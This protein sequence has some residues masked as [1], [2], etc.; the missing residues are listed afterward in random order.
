M[1]RPSEFFHGV[2]FGAGAAR[3]VLYYLLIAVIG[4]F[5]NLWWSGVARVVELP[6]P[7]EF[8]SWTAA[9]SV[10]TGLVSFFATPFLAAIGLFLWCGLLHV[11]VLM[12]SRQRRG[13][14]ATVRAVSY[15]AGPTVLAIVP[16]VGGIIGFF[17]S[18]A[19]TAIGLREGHRMSVGGAITVV[20]LG[21]L[22]P[23]GLF[24]SLFLLMA[25]VVALG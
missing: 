17:W 11:L 18:L 22:I 14:R 5:F 2:P 7:S 21:V 23:L 24:I 3:P 12:F 15:G 6:G 13:F 1:L 25:S 10:A 8:G 19:M 4:A 20:A 9:P 16:I